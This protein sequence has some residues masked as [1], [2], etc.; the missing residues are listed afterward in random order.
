MIM[1]RL[2]AGVERLLGTA[3]FIVTRAAGHLKEEYRQ[4]PDCSASPLT[5]NPFLRAAARYR[6]YRT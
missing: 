2:L 6:E 5:E 1:I 3:G 4:P